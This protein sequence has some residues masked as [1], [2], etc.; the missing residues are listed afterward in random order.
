M[1]ASTD[2]YIHGSDN[3]DYVRKNNAK[4]DRIGLKKY[5]TGTKA[6]RI[7]AENICE[8]ETVSL[9][10]E[11]YHPK[12]DTFIPCLP[13]GGRQNIESSIIRTKDPRCHTK[14]LKGQV[15]LI[16]THLP[17]YEIA[18]KVFHAAKDFANLPDV[19]NEELIFAGVVQ[20]HSMDI[21]GKV[22]L[23]NTTERV[24]F[25]LAQRGAVN[26]VEARFKASLKSQKI[27]VEREVLI[28][29]LELK[30]KQKLQIDDAEI[31]NAI[32]HFQQVDC[33]RV[34]VPELLMLPIKDEH[35]EVKLLVIVGDAQ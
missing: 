19:E 28:Q 12:L 4:K 30:A 31:A 26:D 33:G 1:V 17:A 3:G 18:L 8:Y 24:Y 9:Y 15:A 13:S 23:A 6:F 10:L 5:R 16:S 11:A 14:T 34:T 25:S 22:T 27:P 2:S 35:E 29:A 7:R 20:T 21:H 32:A